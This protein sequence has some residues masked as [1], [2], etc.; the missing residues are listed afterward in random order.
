MASPISEIR[1]RRRRT[2]MNLKVALGS[3]SEKGAPDWSDGFTPTSRHSLFAGRESGM[4]QFERFT[5]SRLSDCNGFVKETL[6]G[7]GVIDGNAPIPA[8]RQAPTESDRPTS[9]TSGSNLTLDA[10]AV[11]RPAKRTLTGARRSA[12]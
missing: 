8:I 4:G 7:L 9:D 3:A 6:A 5:P 10:R 11:T 12:R 1:D 2:T